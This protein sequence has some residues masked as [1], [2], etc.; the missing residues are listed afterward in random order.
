MYSDFAY[1]Y[2]ALMQDVDYKKR[3]DYICSLFEIFDR[4][5]TL[6]LDLACGTGEFSNRF[7]EKGVSVIG[8]D[9]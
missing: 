4:M 8:V 9:I 7:A 5:P 3:T 2:D 6:M 1:S